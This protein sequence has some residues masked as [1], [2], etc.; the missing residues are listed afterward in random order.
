[1]DHDQDYSDNDFV[2]IIE[3]NDDYDDAHLFCHID[4]GG[5]TPMTKPQSM[6]MRMSCQAGPQDQDIFGPQKAKCKT[7]R[8]H[9]IFLRFD[10]DL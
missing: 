5:T 1:M 10:K 4:G 9:D 6:R 8:C 7:A 2:V 3:Y